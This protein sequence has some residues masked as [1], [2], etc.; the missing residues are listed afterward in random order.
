M[1]F[2]P[3]NQQCQS[4]EG[5]SSRQHIEHKRKLWMPIHVVPIITNTA[6]TECEAPSMT[7]YGVYLSVLASSRRYRSIAV[8]VAVRRENAGSAMMSAWLV[9]LCIVVNLKCSLLF[10]AFGYGRRLII[11]NQFGL[12]WYN[13]RHISF[14]ENTT[15]N[16]LQSNIN[17]ANTNACLL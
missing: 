13:S 9:I 2:L 4:T 10:I 7:Q 5:K 15:S 14:T 12:L 1:P 6:C 11:Q 3:P 16:I 8:C 17:S